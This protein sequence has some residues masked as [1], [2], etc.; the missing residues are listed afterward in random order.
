MV[1][2][3]QRFNYE[4]NLFILFVF[5]G[6]FLRVWICQFGSNMDFALWQ[7]NLDLFKEGKSIYEFGNYTYATPWIYTLY[8]LDT[9]SFPALENTKFVQNIPGEF[10]RIKIVIFLSFIDFLI[11]LLLFRNYS[12]KIGL[13][14]F[15]N[16]ISI[17][18]TG[19]HNQFSQYAILFGFLSILLYENKNINK[20]I[21]ISSLLLG[22]SLAVKHILIFFPLWWAFKEKKII[23]KIIVIVV[24]Y[25]IFI[26]S[27]FPFLINEFQYVYENVLINWK[28]EDGPF[29]GM[30]GPKIIH[31][32]F[33]LQTLFSLLLVILGFLFVDKKLKE[34]FYFYLM[35]VVIFSSMMYTQYL[36]IPLIALAVYWNWKFLLYTLLT[37]LLFLVDG[38]QLNLEFLRDIF[39]WDLRATRIAFYP[40]IL[41]LF[42]AF[43]EETIGKKKFYTF[44][45][46]IIKFVS[47]KIR[48]SIKFKI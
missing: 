41:V 40:I 20:R 1:Y 6:F 10:Y 4:L 9:L 27:F 22:I 15:L 46:K 37:F 14:F 8:I 16:P 25:S 47:Q 13:L 3:N 48:S 43:L 31:M 42:I 28:R 36:V 7:A 11:F 33:S 2:K 45:N 17:I 26:L 23:N 19:H 34:S 30:F 5:V 21:L 32:Y 12:L 18:I 38:D 29:W 35:A 44:T 24:P 39:E